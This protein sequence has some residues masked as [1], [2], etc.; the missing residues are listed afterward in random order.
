VILRPYQERAVTAIR[1]L[2]DRRVCLVA[3]TG[4]GKTTMGLAAVEDRGRVLW[5]CPR[6]EIRRQTSLA[7]HL[8]QGLQ[9][10]T[11]QRL[12]ASGDRPEADVLVWDECHHV[13]SD[14]W[15]TI[16]DH[17]STQ[18]HLGLTATPQRHDG[19]PLGDCY[20][21]LVVAA[22]YS[23][24]IR[25]GY[26]VPAVVYQ[27]P[28][29]FV[30][31][32][33][34]DLAVAP[35]EAYEKYASGRQGFG[36][37]PTKKLCEQYA[38]T[39]LDTTVFDSTPKA[40]R[41]QSVAALARGELHLIWSVQTMT[42]GVDVPRASCVVLAGTC[43]NAGNYLQKCGR[44]MRPHPG[45]TD[46]V[47]VDLVG[48]TIL[49][50]P[51]DQDWEYSLG[52]RGIKRTA[53]VAMRQCIYCSAVYESCLPECPRCGKEQ[54]KPRV[55]A[56]KI[57]SLELQRVFDGADTP[58]NAKVAEWHRLLRLCTDRGKNPYFAVKEYRKL[59]GKPAPELLA[60]MS[61]DMRKKL[62]ESIAAKSSSQKKAI[63]KS[64]TGQWPPF[65]WR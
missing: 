15:R 64:I 29:D 48:A 63:Y 36:F 16:A 2:G 34:R 38:H 8:Q 39:L 22:N 35:S 55:R 31:Q 45:K 17:Y 28:V 50:G 32:R 27:P 54:P 20:Q 56:P 51:P 58:V 10:D 14:K 25:D 24:L 42:E 9:V 43:E 40:E 46:C 11:V 12:L 57:W 33:T 65:S 4:S 61:T 3:P 1:E 13:A 37:A 41:E 21:D 26:L 53:V 23:E 62:Y 7:G 18:P 52:G 19:R 59:F 47:I 6:V 60:M 30:A 44:G 49:H 5:L